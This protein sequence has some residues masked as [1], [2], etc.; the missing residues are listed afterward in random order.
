[1]IMVDLG[2]FKKKAKKE[3]ELR[4]N[5]SMINAAKLDLPPPPAPTGSGGLDFPD[6]PNFS[7]EKQKIVLPPVLGEEKPGLPEEEKVEGLD[8][9]W[10]EFM[11][12]NGTPETEVQKPAAE[13]RRVAKLEPQV[14]RLDDAHPLFIEINNY[15]SF[16]DEI[17]RLRVKLQLL[18]GIISKIDGLREKE[19][20]E[21]KRWHLGVDDIR[22][23]LLFIDDA[24]FESRG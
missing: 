2:F 4:L 1:M 22:K 13:V 7:D 11:K 5:E 20:T 8:K 17:G 21:L 9:S 15:S 19:E 14:I 16:L 23:K 3:D 24:L 12:L 10:Q 18:G 6:Y